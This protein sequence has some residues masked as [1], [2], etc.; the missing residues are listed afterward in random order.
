MFNMRIWRKSVT[1]DNAAE[2]MQTIDPR[3]YLTFAHWR[4]CV[5]SLT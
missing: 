2:N 4:K 5:D 1:G 3:H